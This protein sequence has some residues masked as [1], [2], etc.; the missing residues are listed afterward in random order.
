MEIDPTEQEAVQNLPE[1]EQQQIDQHVRKELPQLQEHMET[2]DPA[3][4][5]TDSVDYGVVLSGNSVNDKPIP[6]GEGGKSY[7]THDENCNG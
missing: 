4:H 2:E 5:T 7:K 3:M 1:T 6:H